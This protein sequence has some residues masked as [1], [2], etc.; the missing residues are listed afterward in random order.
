MKAIYRI[1][2]KRGRITIPYET[3]VRV[4]FAYNDILSFVEGPD[5]KSVIVRRE[6][7]CNDCVSEQE[8]SHK[9]DSDG[10]TLKDFLNG[11]TEEQQRAAF[12]Y[13]NLKWGNV[14]IPQH[15]S[16]AQF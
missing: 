7:I 9:D 4:G 3:R 1:M 14:R 6:K 11:L 8:D 16:Q 13:L 10:I 15:V 5:G 2:G 12:T